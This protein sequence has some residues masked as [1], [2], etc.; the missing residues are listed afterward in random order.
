MYESKKLQKSYWDQG[1]W[2][3]TSMDLDWDHMP[4]ILRCSFIN[5]SFCTFQ[6]KD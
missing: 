1:L 4:V 5:N 2:S 6:C 3:K